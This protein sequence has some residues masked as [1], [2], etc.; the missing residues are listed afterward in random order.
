MTHLLTNSAARGPKPMPAE[1]QPG[2]AARTGRAV[3]RLFPLVRSK[4]IAPIVSSGLQLTSVPPARGGNVSRQRCWLYLIRLECPKRRYRIHVTTG[5]CGK[6]F[7]TSLTENCFP[8]RRPACAD[9]RT[10]AVIYPALLLRWFGRPLLLK[11]RQELFAE[12]LHLCFINPKR[13]DVDIRM[14]IDEARVPI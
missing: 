13:C 5:V 7:V 14:R 3:R 11:A 1:P 10:A 8:A 4:K 2:G 12:G 9:A 6:L